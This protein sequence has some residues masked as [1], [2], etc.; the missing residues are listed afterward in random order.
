MD[1]TGHFNLNSF[2]QA[3]LHDSRSVECADYIFL[4]LIFSVLSLDRNV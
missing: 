2:Y 3:V 1:C 4:E